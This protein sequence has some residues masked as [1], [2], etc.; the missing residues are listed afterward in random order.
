M[1]RKLQARIKEVQDDM[2][3]LKGVHTDDFEE[4]CLCYCHEC[5]LYRVLDDKLNFL[6][7]ELEA[8]GE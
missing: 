7:L 2:E 1:V 4:A 3:V 8:K 5:I 6:E